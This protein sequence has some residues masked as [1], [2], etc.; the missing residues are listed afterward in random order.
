MEICPRI[1]C[2]T[3]RIVLLVTFVV[4]VLGQ[5]ENVAS[6]SPLPLGGL[7]DYSDGK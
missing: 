5:Q 3:T 7:E 6:A 4:L 1:S 2:W